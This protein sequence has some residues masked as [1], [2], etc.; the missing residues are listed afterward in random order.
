MQVKVRLVAIQVRQL[1]CTNNL[2]N[3]MHSMTSFSYALASELGLD[4]H[5]LCQE[6]PEYKHFHRS[7]R[8]SPM[9]VDLVNIISLQH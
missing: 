3:E 6:H 1:T 8:H 7:R 2:K 5:I 9:F 4:N